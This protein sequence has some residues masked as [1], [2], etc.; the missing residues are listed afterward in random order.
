MAFTTRDMQAR[1]AAYGC[2]PGPIDGLMGRKTK[3]AARE[4]RKLFGRTITDDV[5]PSGLHRIIL[6]WTAGAEG[7]IELER[8]HYNLIIGQDARAHLGLYKPEA[9]GRISGSY[10]AHTRAMN[11]GSIGVALDAMAGARE[12]PFWAGDAPITAA[13]IEVMTREVADLSLTYRIP[14]SPWTVL[15]HAEVQPTLGVWQRAKWDITWLPGMDG[16]GDP[17]L[18]GDRLRRQIMAQMPDQ[19]IAA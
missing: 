13:M 16:P 14:V 1:L 17:V 5:H 12:R 19:S 3:A 6:H 10:A 7:V 15:S 18:V 8:Q 2:N 4:F 11:S 9:N